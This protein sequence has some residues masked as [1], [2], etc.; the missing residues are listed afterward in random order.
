V[1]PNTKTH[2]FQSLISSHTNGTA[3]RSIII[4][5]PIIFFIKNPVYKELPVSFLGLIIKDEREALNSRFSK[6]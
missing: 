6:Q 2:P 1:L 5:Y 3:K 4:A